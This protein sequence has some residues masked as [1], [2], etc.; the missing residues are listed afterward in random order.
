MAG[1]AAA[2]N[3]KPLT[4]LCESAFELLFRTSNVTIKGEASFS[5]D[6]NWFK[7]AKAEYIQDGDR[8][9]WELKLSSPKMDGTVRENGYTIIADGSKVYVN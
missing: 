4:D 8:S 5:L 2:E 3:E 9:F 6:G 7:T 1:N